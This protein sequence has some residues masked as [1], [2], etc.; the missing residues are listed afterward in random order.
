MNPLKKLK[1]IEGTLKA[2][3]FIWFFV[4]TAVTTIIKFFGVDCADCWTSYREYILI[5]SLPILSGIIVTYLNRSETK[6]VENK[7]DSYYRQTQI[8]AL[9]ANIQNAYN[10]WHEKDSLEQEQI[11]YLHALRHQLEE[12]GVNSFSQATLKKLLDK[13]DK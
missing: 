6:R 10:F 1:D 11:K 13:F 8:T 5:I 2:G 9:K 4:I 12:F 7:A 3:I